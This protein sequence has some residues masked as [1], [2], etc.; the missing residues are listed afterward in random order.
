[1][2]AAVKMLASMLEVLGESQQEHEP[3][4]DQRGFGGHHGQRSSVFLLELYIY[5]ADRSEEGEVTTILLVLSPA[6]R[7]QIGWGHQT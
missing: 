5:L 3:A 6:A 1:M 2:R 7:E 4:P